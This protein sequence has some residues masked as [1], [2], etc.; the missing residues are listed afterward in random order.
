MYIESCPL[1]PIIVPFS[2]FCYPISKFSLLGL[3]VYQA[4]VHRFESRILLFAVPRNGKIVN[5]N[6][7]EYGE[8]PWQVSLRQWREGE[9]GKN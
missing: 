8:W 3:L 6:V 4:R 2:S 9:P 7:S 5:G 1:K